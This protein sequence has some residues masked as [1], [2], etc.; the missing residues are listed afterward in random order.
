MNSLPSLLPL[1]DGV[2]CNDRMGEPST[3]G[4][5]TVSYGWD[6]IVHLQ[7]ET[8]ENVALIAMSANVVG[9]FLLH[10]WG[11]GFPGCGFDPLVDFF[12]CASLAMITNRFE[13]VCTDNGPV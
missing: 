11:N 12:A 10:G 8:F 4:Y 7:P 2:C 5:E 6:F 9:H 13:V 1:K 3:Y